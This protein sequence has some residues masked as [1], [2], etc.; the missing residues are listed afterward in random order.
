MPIFLLFV[1]LFAMW[2]R[3]E[4]KKNSQIESDNKTSFIERE[5]QANF[6]RRADIA[7]LDYVP[8]RTNMMR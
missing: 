3:Y 1:I 2:I 6:A 8:F 7:N 5:R 4:I